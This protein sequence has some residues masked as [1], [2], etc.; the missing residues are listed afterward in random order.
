MIDD[1]TIFVVDDDKSVRDSLRWLLESLRHKVETYASAAEFLM[2]CDPDRPGCLVLDVRM[3]E[4]SGL[5]LQEILATRRVQLPVVMI[6]GHGDV[7]MAVRAMKAGA[8]DFIE[9]PFNDQLF[10]ECI[11]RGLQANACQRR[12]DAQ[13]QTVQTRMASL[14]AREREV[15]ERVVAGKP[16]KM[17]AAELGISARTVE[18]H[19]AHLMDKMRADSLATLTAMCMPVRREQAA[20]S[21]DTYTS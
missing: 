15:L 8:F 5:Q 20:L 16:N 14:T 1:P 19:R 21:L 4:V 13:R 7:A 9:K 17:I 11:Q 2:H 3:P 6:T 10:L 18:V 12:Q